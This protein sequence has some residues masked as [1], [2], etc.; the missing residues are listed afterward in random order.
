MQSPC[1]IRRDFESSQTTA[2][3]P[4]IPAKGH[5]PVLETGPESRM[6]CRHKDPAG[7]IKALSTIPSPSRERVRVKFPASTTEPAEYDWKSCSSINPVD[8][9]SD[10]IPKTRQS[11]LRITVA[12]IPRRDRMSH[13]ETHLKRFSYGT[14]HFHLYLAVEFCD[15]YDKIDSRGRA[16]RGDYT[17]RRVWTSPMER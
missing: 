4:D 1:R 14:R 10:N 17:K 7:A 5:H 9:D 11:D 12:S 15:E 2:G 6:T 13:F 16:R 3:S 8:L